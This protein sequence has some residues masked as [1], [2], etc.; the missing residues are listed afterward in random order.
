[1]PGG[2][3]LS[4]ADD[5]TRFGHGGGLQRTST[6]MVLDP[7]RRTGV[8]ILSNWENLELEPLA[9]ALLASATRSR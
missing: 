5:M 2:G 7:D 8:V 1:V 9:A 6:L 4:S 3:W